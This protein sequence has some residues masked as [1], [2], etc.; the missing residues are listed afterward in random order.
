MPFDVFLKFETIKGESNDHKHKGEIDV[1]SWTWNITNPLRGRTVVEDLKIYKPID[2]ATP[3]LFDAACAGE[4]VGTAWLSVRKAG[5]KQD[6]D[7]LQIVLEDVVITSI[8]SG[9]NATSDSVPMEEIALNFSK[10]EIEY[11]EQK[12]DGTTGK[13]TKSSCSPRRTWPVQKP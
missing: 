9:G 12:E 6:I 2:G 8:R 13:S 3:P 10:I 11:T 1:L 7:F 5:G 4:P